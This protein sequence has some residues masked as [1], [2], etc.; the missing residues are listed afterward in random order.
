MLRTDSLHSFSPCAFYLEQPAS[1]SPPFVCR[2]WIPLGIRSSL[3]LMISIFA[4]F[5]SSVPHFSQHLLPPTTFHLPCMDWRPWKKQMN[6][7]F[8]VADKEVGKLFEE[9]HIFSVILCFAV[10]FLNLLISFLKLLPFIRPL[11]PGYY[12]FRRWIK[13]FSNSLPCFILTYFAFRKEIIFFFSQWNY[14]LC[15]RL[16]PSTEFWSPTTS[17]VKWLRKR[18]FEAVIVI[19]IRLISHKIPRKKKLRNL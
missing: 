18:V 3:R 4:S 16:S 13:F 1:L 14:Q 6:T 8:G 19:F 2:P 10:V 5:S 12:N 15:R 17:R 9:F 7:N 11:L